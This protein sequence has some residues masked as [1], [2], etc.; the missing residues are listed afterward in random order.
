MRQPRLIVGLLV[1][2]LASPGYAEQEPTLSITSP[3][4]RLQLEFAVCD[5]GDDHSCPVYRLFQA[6]TTLI[7]SSRLFLRRLQRTGPRVL[8]AP[9][10]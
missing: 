4:N 1:T 5:M 6:G 2:L 7:E 8:V 3:D 9:S 10:I